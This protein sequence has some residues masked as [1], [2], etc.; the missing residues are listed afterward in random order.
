MIV[1]FEGR[2]EKIYNK[3]RNILHKYE[4]TINFMFCQITLIICIIILM[5]LLRPFIFNGTCS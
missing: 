1:T 3:E 5:L 4:T 2:H